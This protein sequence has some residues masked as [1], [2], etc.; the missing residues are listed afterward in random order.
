M[1]FDVAEKKRTTGFMSFFSSTPGK[2]KAG[3]SEFRKDLMRIEILKINEDE[4]G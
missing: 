1:T 2:T 3:A 4:G